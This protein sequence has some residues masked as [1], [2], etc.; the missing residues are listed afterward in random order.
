MIYHQ[1]KWWV[2][3]VLAFIVVVVTMVGVALAVFN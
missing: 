2:A 3:P 1:T